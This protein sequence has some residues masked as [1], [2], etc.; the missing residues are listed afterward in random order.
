MNILIIQEAGRH[1]IN[2]DFRE[3]LSMQRALTDLG[4]L[5]EVWGLGHENYENDPDWQSYDV[6]LNLENY[7]SIGW[8]PDLSI[9]DRPKKI[10][11]SIDAHCRGLNVYNQIYERGNYD[12]MLQAT[13]DFVGPNSCWFP[14]CYDSSLIKEDKTV[15]REHFLGFCGSIL[16][17]SDALQFLEQKYSLKKDIWKLGKEMVKAVS[18][19]QVHFNMNLSVDINYRSF[20]TL[21]CGTALLTNKNHQY[22]E[23]G[24]VDG[25]NSIIYS[26]VTDIVDKLNYYQ[27]NPKEV[28]KIQSNSLKLA[29]EHTYDKRAALL[30]EIINEI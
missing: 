19:Y 14:N 4:H 24:F 3:C 26:S 10:L 20:E 5:V 18:S 30:M 6:I 15:K 23:L 13:K 2:K 27:K 9:I 12:L 8:L 28:K 29:K 7:D 22:D 25:E 1:E 16:N 17:R 11:W 21:G